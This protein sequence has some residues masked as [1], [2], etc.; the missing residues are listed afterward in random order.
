M[1]QK[2]GR[3]LMTDEEYAKLQDDIKAEIMLEEAL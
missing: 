3:L 1:V 2:N